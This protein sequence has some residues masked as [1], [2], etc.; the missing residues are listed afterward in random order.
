MLGLHKQWKA[1]QND[2]S[3]Q[4]RDKENVIHLRYLK[5][6]NLVASLSRFVAHPYNDFCHLENLSANYKQINEFRRVRPADSE[7]DASSSTK[8]QRGMKSYDGIILGGGHNG[9]ILQAYLSRAGVTTVCLEQ[10]DKLGGGL[11]TVEKP[12]ESGFFHNTHSFY[13][14]GITHSPWYRDLQ[15]EEN[16]ACYIEPELNVAMVC[17]DGPLLEWWTDFSSTYASFAEVSPVDADKL[18]FWRNEFRPIVEKFLSPEALAPPLPPDERKRQLASSSLGR[19]LLEVSALS[20]LKFVQQEFVHPQVR[21]ALLFFNGLREVD[22][23][24]PGFGHHIPALL[25]ADRY[26]QICKGGSG[27]LAEA[28]EKVI[29]K[30]GGEIRTK[31][32]PQRIHI[33]NGRATG[34]ETDDG[35]FLRATRFV[36]SSLNPQQTFLGLIDQQHLPTA[37][38]S[39]ARDFQY[40]LIAP[41]FSLNLNLKEAPTYA[42]SQETPQLQQALMVILG[43][44]SS[45][46]FSEIVQHHERGTIPPTVM[47]GS[48]PS[49]FDPSQAPPESH[50]AFMWEKL[51][52]RLNGNPLEWDEQKKQHGKK[53]LEAWKLRAPNL[54]HAVLDSFVQSPLDTERRLPNMVGGDLLVGSFDNNQ[55]GY[56]RPFIGAGHYRGHLDALYLCGSSCHPG[57]NV[58]GLPAYNCAQVLL[59]DLGLKHPSAQ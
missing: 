33:E 52:Y 25:A 30:H 53:M 13:H 59:A 41:L 38:L 9:L 40:N 16:G 58:T 14:R 46:Q 19:R 55:I 32:K 8:R 5:P 2:N 37:W 20:P 43:L 42:A 34:V 28:L 18:Q 51:P 29:R 27:A 21:A 3:C 22:L 23:R 56:H 1:A 57:G 26:A 15:L 17:S 39:A 11:T 6:R 44:D 54:E 10:H 36:A 7:K 48:C 50:T 31:T 35:E 49:Q 24:L 12:L 4:T 47:W 45:E